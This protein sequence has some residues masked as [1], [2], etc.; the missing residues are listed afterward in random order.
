[1]KEPHQNSRPAHRPLRAAS[2][3]IAGLLGALLLGPINTA[4][5]GFRVP[6]QDPEAIARGNAFAATADNPSAIYYNPAGITQLEGQSLSA[7]LYLISADTEYTSPTGAGAQT[8]TDFQP[9]PQFYY[10]NSLKNVP[11]SFGLGVYAPYGLSLDWGENPPFRTLAENGK[12][13]YA[14]V[15]PIVAWQVH[16]ALSV[17]IGPTINYSRVTFQQG[18][19]VLPGDHFKVKGDGIDY[20]FNAGMR[21][22][23]HE[24]WALGINY[25]YATTVDYDGHSET[26]PA[27]PPPYFPSTATRAAIRFPQ[28]V[29][30]GVSYRPAKDW[31]FE[32]DVDWT[33]WDNLNQIVF[34][35]IGAPPLVLNYRSSLMYEFGITRRLGKG[36]FVS[37]GYIFSENSSPDQNF[38]PIVPD[39]DLHL[40]SIGFGHK[41]RRWDWALGYH[42][43]YNPGREVKGSP[44]PPLGSSADGAYRTLNHAINLSTTLKF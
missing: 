29:A 28:F 14:T 17:G 5:V 25:R 24:K 42:F 11:L 43:A 38:N 23:P 19:G 32:F 8:K 27:G 10:V 37:T 4:A 16:P 18:I 36:Y 6:N 31:N 1:M 2:G 7:G 12:I 20:G 34:R 44:V 41:G 3:G 15:N 21:W 22:Q 35:G 13:L 30:A 33:D 9:V 26:I 39:A 40:G